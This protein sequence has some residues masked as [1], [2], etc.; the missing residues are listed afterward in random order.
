MITYVLICLYSNKHCFDLEK[1][2]FKNALCNFAVYYKDICQWF[3]ELYILQFDGQKTVVLY[4]DQK[5]KLLI[6][7]LRNKLP[8]IQGLIALQ[9]KSYCAAIYQSYAG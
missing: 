5:F 3:N 7:T 2:T 1:N 9:L 8:A 4:N 6:N